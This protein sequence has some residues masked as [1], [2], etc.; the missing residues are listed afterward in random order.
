MYTVD[1][2]TTAAWFQAKLVKNKPDPPNRAPRKTR[3]FRLA[4]GRSSWETIIQAAMTMKMQVMA[5]AKYAH[6]HH[7]SC[8]R[9]D[10]NT[11]P[12][13]LAGSGACR[14]SPWNKTYKEVSDETFLMLHTSGSTG[15]SKSVP[16]KHSTL[17]S[18]DA[19]QLLHDVGE[20]CVASKWA[21]RCV[22][23]ALPPFHAAGWNF[24][25]FSIFQSTKLVLGPSEAPPSVSTVD[26]VLKHGLAQL[27]LWLLHYSPK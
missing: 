18:V 2:P 22:Y 8:A 23:T 27:A 11:A 14:P 6:G 19:Q 21:N 25:A 3:S 24:F 1:H 10:E 20:R 26:M 16:Q 17:A 9:M 5:R 12:N 7:A 15:S 4:A 13:D